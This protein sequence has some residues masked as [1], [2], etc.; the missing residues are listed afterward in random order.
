[1][2]N[3]HGHSHDGAVT[4]NIYRSC[5]PLPV[6]NPGSLA[7]GEFAEMTINKTILNKWK[8]QEVNKH[9]LDF[10]LSDE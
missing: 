3:I 4:Q 8:V 1:V 10:G 5:E 9:F 2:C 6:I 7:Q